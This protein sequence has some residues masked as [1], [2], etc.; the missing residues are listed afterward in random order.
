MGTSD[1]DR[2]QERRAE[3]ERR[4]IEIERK[5]VV[6]VERVQPE[7]ERGHRRRVE[8]V[9]V[10]EDEDVDRPIELIARVRIFRVG[11]KLRSGLDE[12]WNR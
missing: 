2:I 12:F 8:D 4:W 6:V 10:V 11:K 7:T 5:A 9:G 3:A 1:L